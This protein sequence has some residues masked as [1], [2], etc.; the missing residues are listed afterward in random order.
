MKIRKGNQP[1]SCIGNNQ[2]KTLEWA[3]WASLDFY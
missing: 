2:G 3:V 1:T